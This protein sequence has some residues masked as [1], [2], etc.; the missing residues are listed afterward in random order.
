MFC[1]TDNILQNIPHIQSN[2]IKIY[3]HNSY[4]IQ[5]QKLWT[6]TYVVLHLKWSEGT[7]G[8]GTTF[9][10]CSLIP[11]NHIP[12]KYRCLIKKN[13]QRMSA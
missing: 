2:D 6:K 5:F 13:Y 7:R 12:I 11:C 3:K 8:N 9:G 10:V 4:N 1:A